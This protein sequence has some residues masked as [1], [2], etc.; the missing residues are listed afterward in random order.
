MQCER[1]ARF[2][3]PGLEMAAVAFSYL[4]FSS[5]QQ[6]TG[7]SI[8][9]QTQ[10]RDTWIVAHPNVKLDSSLVMTDAG[11]SGFKRA[12]WDTY[13]L[14]QFVEHVK[15]GRVA[16]GSYLLVENLD[17]LSRENAGEATE[18]FLSI[19]NKGIVVVQL[20][21]AVMEF[22]KPV[23]MVSLM[24]AIV[25]LSRGHSES[26]I[27]CER[28][29]AAWVRKH[30]EAPTRIM[31]RKLPR[32]IVE[33][34]GKLVLD[35][36]KAKIVRRMFQ[37]A[38]D[39]HG[40]SGIARTFNAEGVS[41]LG[42]KTTKGT[43]VVKWAN[44]TVLHMLTSRTA[45]GEF[46]PYATN[47]K[48]PAGEPVPGYYPPVV[49]EAT[50]YAVQEALT[51]RGRVGRGRRGKHVNLFAGLLVDA[52]GGGPMTYRHK[53]TEPSTIIPYDARENR[54]TK[55][56]S[57]PAAVFEDA[58]LEQL[59]EVP[60][61][62]LVGGNGATTRVA[63]LGGRKAEL[64]AVIR[65]WEGKMG[66]LSIIEVVASNLRKFKA[67]LDDVNSNLAEANQEAA[68][69]TGEALGSVKTLAELLRNDNS[70]EL[71]LKCRAA[72][73]RAIAS[74]HCLFVGSMHFRRAAVRIQFR[75]TDA[76]RDYLIDCLRRIGNM[77]GVPSPR[78][79]S[80]NWT[81]QGDELDLRRPA[82]A[83]IVEKMLNDDAVIAAVFAEA[84]KQKAKDAEPKKVAFQKKPKGG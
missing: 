65:A 34:G 69:P 19:V 44:P 80:A 55:Y 18:L 45:I 33:K 51:T 22:K 48:Q 63:E 26:A 13:A 10:A 42:R 59:A 78:V 38:L 54:G 46:T 29:K 73:R 40:S 6:A 52:R 81:D 14:A 28:S 37:M 57:F 16:K 4:R 11:R 15:S 53:S 30:K 7:D 35:A 71:R 82:D 72:L 8:R 61:A 24:F 2:H 58:I 1:V 36:E 3:F 56:V 68:S 17:R 47:G 43:R 32:W 79:T 27:K 5:P 62:E 66:D 49:S 67:E 23:D 64:E 77:K 41:V 25:E 70:D 20:S 60:A 39:G 21:P 83:K 50:F 9:R 84:E 75:G 31:T 74:V 76:H 12:N